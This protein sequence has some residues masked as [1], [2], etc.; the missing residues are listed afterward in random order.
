MDGGDMKQKL[1]LDFAV[2]CKPYSAPI[3]WLI[4]GILLFILSIVLYQAQQ[5]KS[6]LAMKSESAGIRTHT[7]KA[8]LSPI[9]QHRLKLAH[10]TRTALN[11]SWD[12]MLLSLE[13]AQAATPDMRLLAVQPN[14]KKGEVVINGMVHDFAI[15][16][17]YIAALKNQSTFDDAVL[18][19]QQWDDAPEGETQLNFIIA[20]GWK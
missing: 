8:K 16:A 2:K 5:L 14:A 6:E 12:E 15:L 13:K 9:L 20:V 19:R 17:E 4:A 7:T 18:Q 3:L 11:V 10:Q 1:D